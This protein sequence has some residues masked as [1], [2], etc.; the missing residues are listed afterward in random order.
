MDK[1][2]FKPMALALGGV[3]SITYVLDVLGGLLWPNSWL[4][5]KFWELVLPGFRWLSF[6]SFLWGLIAS[7]LV[8]VYL[9][10]VFVPLY[11]YFSR[12]QPQES[13]TSVSRPMPGHH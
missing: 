5:Y 4:M 8:G 9:A 2:R 3:L 1:V 13:P 7:F 10:A 12:E 11:N 6:G